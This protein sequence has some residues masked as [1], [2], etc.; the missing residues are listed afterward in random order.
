M[1]DSVTTP[2]V[3]PIGFLPDCRHLA[4]LAG[5]IPRCVSSMIGVYWPDGA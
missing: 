3:P 2:P 5:M 4:D 1:V